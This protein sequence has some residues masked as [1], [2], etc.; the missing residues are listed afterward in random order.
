MQGHGPEELLR[1]QGACTPSLRHFVASYCFEDA[2][3]LRRIDDVGAFYAPHV[4]KTNVSTSS[5][6]A[7]ERYTAADA[8]TQFTFFARNESVRYAWW[9][10]EALQKNMSVADSFALRRHS[11]RRAV[12]RGSAGLSL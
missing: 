4:M 10:A 6:S 1:P 12:P 7:R 8:P 2:I 9:M 5:P 11:G 3:T